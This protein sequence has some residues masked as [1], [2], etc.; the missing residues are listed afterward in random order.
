M[1]HDFLIANRNT[2]I[3]RCRT[4]VAV[5]RAPRPTPA[6]LEFGIPL[7]L[8]QL[9]DMLAED[10]AHLKNDAYKGI[11]AAEDARLR[12]S[13]GKHGEELRRHGFTIEQV[14]RDYGDL[15]QSITHLAAEQGEPISVQE[16]GVL[17]IKLDDAIAGAVAE[18]ARPRMPNAANDQVTEAKESLGELAHEMRN[19]LNTTILA[20]SA[21][22]GGS[23][24]FNGATAA[25]LDRSLIGMRGLIDRT[26][27]EVRL[28]D[29]PSSPP[30]VLEIAPFILDVQVAAALE[31]AT[32]GC[33]LTVTPVEPGIFVE[34]DGHILAA[35]LAN[36]LQNAFKFTRPGTHVLLRTYASKS[37]VLMEVED[38]CGGLA[39]GISEEIFRPFQQ[40][41]ADR[42]GLGLGLTISR[43]AVEA[44]GGKLSVRNIPGVGCVFTIDIPRKQVG[45]R[46]LAEAHSA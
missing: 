32:T 14:V 8:T 15:C 45:V 10:P 30:Q 21:I 36:L 20:I 41:G 9:T 13:A 17:N 7:F 11:V 37:R 40:S 23:V 4:K 29:A 42:S 1:L 28:G 44:S 39:P 38:E 24:G 31:A 34:A 27:A 12:I 3:E 6:E 46:P 35:A 18:H 43:R 2:L 5:R 22:K 33:E 16:F 19:L 25:A 26:L